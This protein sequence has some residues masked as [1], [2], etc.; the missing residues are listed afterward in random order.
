M[1]DRQQE[2]IDAAIAIIAEDGIQRLT[3]KELSRRIGISEPAL[4][5]HFENKLAILVAILEHFAEWSARTLQSIIESDRRP[6]EKIRELFRQHTV[7]FME[8]PATSGVLFAEEIFKDPQELSDAVMRTIGVAE[9]YVRQILEEGITAGVFRSDVPLEHLALTTMGS[10]R[11][12]VTR[13]RLG[14]YRFNLHDEGMH[15]AD[16]MVRQISAPGGSTAS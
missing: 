3:T 14:R 5:R 13:W 16:S 11:L 15:L 10:L 4:Y 9:G 2:I 7:R 8:S 1:T 6:D 12:L